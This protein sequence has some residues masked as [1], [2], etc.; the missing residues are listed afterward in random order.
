MMVAVAV[1]RS[2]SIAARTPGSGLQFALRT[3]VS[4]PAM[5]A[6]APGFRRLP[7]TARRAARVSAPNLAILSKRSRCSLITMG[8]DPA[9]D[10]PADLVDAARGVLVTALIKQLQL[11]R[12]PEQETQL[13]TRHPREKRGSR[14]TIEASVPGFPLSA[15]MTN[16]FRIF[17][18][19]LELR[20]PVRDCVCRS[21]RPTPPVHRALC[22]QCGRRAGTFVAAEIGRVSGSA[23]RR[24]GRPAPGPG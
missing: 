7:R 17:G 23:R 3:S 21:P 15:G 4:S 24:T 8:P 10:Q 5:K 1:A 14:V 22:F 9:A 20:G 11:R 13:G 16:Y 12:Q 6:A 19:Y 2:I 18:D